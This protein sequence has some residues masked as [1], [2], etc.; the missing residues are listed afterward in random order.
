MKRAL[1][2]SVIVFVFMITFASVCV[3]QMA[4][5]EWEKTVTLSSGE[6]ILD[7]NGEWDSLHKFPGMKGLTN[8]IEITQEGKTFI[9]I[10][11]QESPYWPKGTEAIKGEL[12]G[13]GF[14]TVSINRAD[15][16]WTP[17]KWEI[18]KN[19]NKILLNDEGV[20]KLT[21]NRR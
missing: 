17:C 3:S 5:K 13:D 8:V 10:R 15:L 11:L 7:M 18:S 16:G 14:K 12:Q 9:G 2:A 1:I 4:E 21:L 20:V 6:V 19:G